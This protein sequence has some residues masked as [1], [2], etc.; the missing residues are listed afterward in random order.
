MQQNKDG[1]Q[2]LYKQFGLFNLLLLLSVSSLSAGSFEDFKRTQN[3]EFASYKDKRDAAFS[4]YLKAQWEEYNAKNSKPLYE[5]Q[6]PKS[7]LKTVQKRVISVGPI[8]KIR[9]KK[10]KKTIKEPTIQQ[11]KIQQPVEKK[12]IVKKESIIEKK[13]VVKKEIITLKKEKQK[14]QKQPEKVIITQKKDINL[15]FFG[16]DIGL[17]IDENFKSARFYPRSQEGISNYFNALAGSEYEN[18]LNDIL[19]IKKELNL[20]DWGV[21]LL[22]NTLSS[23]LYYDS[24]EAKLFTWFFFNK[25]GYSVKVGLHAKHVVLMHY[26]DKIIYSTPRYTFNKKKYYVVS[27]YAKGSAGKVYTY[28]QEY[29]DATKAL[30]L[31]LKT[32]PNFKKDLITKRVSFKEFGKEFHTTYKY[33]K[34][35]IDFMATYPQADYE[36][37]FNAPMSD[38]TYLSIANDIKNYIDGKKS[39]EGINFVLNFVQKAFKY[40]TDQQQ[41]GR[42][43]VMFA[44]ETLY[45]DKSDCEDRA[46]LFSYLI[47]ELFGISVIGVKY[48]DHMATALYIPMKGDSVKAGRR[49]FVIADP[50]YINANIGQSM[51]KYKNKIPESF[52]IVKR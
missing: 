25:L 11:P 39:S 24:D 18:T 5:K 43:K 7:T 37:Y 3:R 20:N 38:E 36:T 23:A 42:E 33:D 31:S 48:K 12:I 13:P 49:E 15:R 17:D 14:V 35:L 26:S 16:Q 50:T 34:N 21:Y 41:F 45:Y 32:L 29:P 19:R 44:D 28:K 2:S 52:I 4:N 8:I 40:K 22:L 51:P 27:N 9:I 47:K 10:P 6:K 30:D 46:I 1:V